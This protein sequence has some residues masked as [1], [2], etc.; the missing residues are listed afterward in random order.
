[1]TT[2]KPDA[3]GFYSDQAKLALWDELVAALDSTLNYKTLT[4]KESAVKARSL[5]TRAKAIK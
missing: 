5:L 2:P 1:M 3:A 4:R